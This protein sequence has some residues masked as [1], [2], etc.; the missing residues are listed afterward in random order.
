MLN[1]RII[2]YR[3]IF[4]LL[5][6]FTFLQVSFSQK[7]WT[8]DTSKDGIS[9]Y[10]KDTPNSDIKQFKL[11]TTIKSD[12]KKVYELLRNVEGMHLWYDKIKSVQMLQKISDNEGV[13]LL[14]YSLPFPLKNRV[15]TVKGKMDFDKKAGI[16]K[17]NTTYQAFAIPANMKDL[18]LI[19]K[20]WSSWEITTL[21][22]GELSIIHMGSMDPGGNIPTWL[23]NDG[24]TTGPIKTINAFKSLLK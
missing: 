16:I 13:Y 9:I 10:T 20:I 19:T 18:L 17:V 14:E 2:H 23:V 22:T 8:L 15:S 7:D 3:I 21:P 4:F 1:A 6:F 24:V 11:V 12:I 5:G